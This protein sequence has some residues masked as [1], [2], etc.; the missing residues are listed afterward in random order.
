MWDSQ[1]GVLLR[2]RFSKTDMKRCS[3]K[4]WSC[5]WFDDTLTGG[6]GKN[7]RDVPSG[8][9]AEGRFDV[10]CR[11]AVNHFGTVGNIASA[12]QTPTSISTL[13]STTNTEIAKRHK[14][15]K[16]NERMKDRPL[17]IQPSANQD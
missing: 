5:Q 12:P 9:S 4:A 17:S 6:S 7:E 14:G 10:A 11:G 1:L 13:I 15:S 2:N 16:G 3:S 8:N